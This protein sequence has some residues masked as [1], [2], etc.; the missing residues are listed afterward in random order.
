M[1][2]NEN[3]KIRSQIITLN[4][5]KRGNHKAVN[6]K[7]DNNGTS[8]KSSN[9]PINSKK[10][11]PKNEPQKDIKDMPED[12]D[13]KKEDKTNSKSIFG[14]SEIDEYLNNDVTLKDIATAKELQSV[15]TEHKNLPTFVGKDDERCCFNPDKI[16][17]ENFMNLFIHMIINKKEEYIIHCKNLS[18]TEVK[19]YVMGILQCIMLCVVVVE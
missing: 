5:K 16:D 10:D 12:I 13:E 3:L 17:L 2:V 9:K 11:E 6:S 7:D 18:F 14:P 15:D 1:M 4:K 19:Q 8:S